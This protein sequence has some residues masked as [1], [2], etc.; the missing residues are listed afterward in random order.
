MPAKL[1]VPKGTRFSRW[2][3][4]REASPAPSSRRFLCKCDCGN[5]AIVLLLSLRSKRSRSCGCL[6]REETIKRLTTHGQSYN[7]LANVWHKIHDRCYKPEDAAYHNYGERG[8]KVWKKWHGDDGLL[9]FIEWAENN[10]YEPG[11]EIDRKNNDK[12][13]RP[14]NCRWVSRK[15]QQRNTRKTIMVL[16]KGK[17]IPFVDLWEKMG[18]RTKYGTAWSRYRNL[19]WDPIEA[20]S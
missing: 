4:I 3:V 9:R 15:I 16:Y 17:S 19:G 20:V 7:P 10:G 18:K 11:L 6:H 5:K 2:K 8:I 14:S 13:Y 1:F 12:G